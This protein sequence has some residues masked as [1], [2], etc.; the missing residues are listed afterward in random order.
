M[1]RLTLLPS[2][3]DLCNLS[4]EEAHFVAIEFSNRGYAVDV[5]DEVFRCTQE[6][7]ERCFAVAS[8]EHVTIRCDD[9]LD[10]P[11]R[12]PVFS[13]QVSEDRLEV[14]ADLHGS[15]FAGAVLPNLVGFTDGEVV[16][17]HLLYCGRTP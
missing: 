9:H 4:H 10:Q 1:R 6:N 16:G 5:L 14:I 13:K 12:G 3:L 11:G 15:E 8:T 2:P 17:G 7:L